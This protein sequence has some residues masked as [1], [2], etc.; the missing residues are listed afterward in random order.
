M[1]L[2]QGTQPLM[3]WSC[4]G[5]HYSCTS[6]AAVRC[7]GLGVVGVGVGFGGGWHLSLPWSRVLVPLK[8]R[9]CDG[10]EEEISRLLVIRQR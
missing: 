10:L 2:W 5:A 7:A 8:N 9:V 4:E 3:W 6:V 1:A